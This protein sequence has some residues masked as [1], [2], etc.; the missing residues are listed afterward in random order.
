MRTERTLSMKVVSLNVGRVAT[1]HY[2]GK[3]VRTGSHKSPVLEARLGPN[4]FEGD[5]QADLRFHGGPDKAVC[6]YSA[7]HYPLWEREWQVALEPGAFGEN[8]TL[9]GVRE[10]DLCIGDILR[11]GETLMQVTQPRQPCSKLAARHGVPDLV[12]K[13]RRNGFSGFY[14]RMLEGGLVRQG[15]PV[16]LATPHPSEVSVSFANQVMF[17]QR[18][19]QASLERLLSVE[20]LSEAWR[21]SLSKRLA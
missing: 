4:G 18:D 13:I 5:E 20:A 12:E 2:A 17:R 16:T 15:D 10:D 8:L 21:E 3:S 11:A 7:D 9:A 1:L 14:L 19:D 6:V